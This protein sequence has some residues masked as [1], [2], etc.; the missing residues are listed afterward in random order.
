MRISEAYTV[1]STPARRAAYDRD[2]LALHSANDAGAPRGS[3]SSTSRAGGR[4]PTGLSK[5][6]SAFRGPPPSFF[7][8]GGGAA[9]PRRTSGASTDERP[10]AAGMGPGQDPFG[11]HDEVLHFDKAAHERT[12]ATIDEIRA[13]SAR[14]R[15]GRHEHYPSAAA[16][17][18]V[19]VGILGVACWLLTR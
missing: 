6:R 3:Y 11:R 4:A 15:R 10:R 7:R 16:N 8:A 14:R 12:H 9:G 2:V 13:A 19:A 17:V 5:R 1:L 18:V